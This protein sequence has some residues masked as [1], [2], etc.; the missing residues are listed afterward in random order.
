[1]FDVLPS[2]LLQILSAQDLELMLCGMPVI[3]VSQDVVAALPQAEKAI[4]IKFSTGSAAVPSQGFEH[5]LGLHGEQCF[6]LSDLLSSPA[7]VTACLLRPHASIC[8]S[9]QSTRAKR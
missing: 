6:T 7:A 5:L 9:C 2:D 3:D 4:L 8:S 1:M